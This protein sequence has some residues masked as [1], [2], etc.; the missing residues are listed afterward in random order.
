MA[1]RPDRTRGAAPDSTLHLRI[2]LFCFGAGCALAGIYYDVSWLITA[3]TIVLAAGL[4]LSL[5][6][7]RRRRAAQEASWR[8]Q[9]EADAEDWETEETRPY[10][11]ETDRHG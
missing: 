5:I 2:L 3:G 4:L 7:S 6:N 11:D 9:A 1:F 10:E 8:E